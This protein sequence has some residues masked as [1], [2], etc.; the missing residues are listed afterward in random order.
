MEA[1]QFAAAVMGDAV[2]LLSALHKMETYYENSDFS[3][4]MPHEE[5]VVYKI[6]SPLRHLMRTHPTFDKRCVA[7]GVRPETVVA[8]QAQQL[9]S[10]MAPPPVPKDQWEHEHPD[11]HFP[12]QEIEK[13]TAEWQA[14]LREKQEMAEADVAER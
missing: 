2:P 11:R 8:Y 3:R 12:L 7:L 10:D 5:G 4:K 6:F 14:R 1:D 9:H 13:T